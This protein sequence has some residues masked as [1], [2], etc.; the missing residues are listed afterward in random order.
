MIPAPAP[1]IGPVSD[2][3]GAA[4]PI[5]SEP[6]MPEPVAP[7]VEDPS[8]G[9]D[10]GR[11]NDPVL[12]SGQSP[13]LTVETLGPRR[14]VI[15]KK[16][17][18]KVAVR[19][20]G[21]VAAQDVILTVNVPA[22][23][24]IVG[25]EAQTAG[26]V[27]QAPGATDQI[28][29]KLPKLE[30]HSREEMLLG[31]IASEGVPLNLSVSLTHSPVATETSVEVSEPKLT[32]VLAGPEEVHYGKQEVF[33]LTL[34]NPGTA[35]AENVEL[36][37]AAANPGDSAPPATK[38]GL[39]PAGSRKVV[40]L[41]LTARQGGSLKIQATATANGNLKADVSETVLIR[42]P[43]LEMDLRGPTLRYSGTPGKYSLAL[44]NSGNSPAKEIQVAALLPAGAEFVSAEGGGTFNKEQGKIVWQLSTLEAE[45]TS[46]LVWVCKLNE[47]GEAK[48]QTACQAD[49]GLKDSANMVTEVEAIADLEMTVSDPRSPLPTGDSVVYDIVLRNRGTRKAENIELEAFLS[50]GL[51]AQ[52]PKTTGL[53][54]ISAGHVRFRR[55]DGIAPGQELTIQLHATGVVAGNQVVRVEMRCPSLDLSIAQEEATR[56]FGD[57]IPTDGSLELPSISEPAA[58]T[59]VGEGTTT[60][61]QRIRVPYGN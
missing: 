1:Q 56:F 8:T 44:H 24:E 14:V 31:V 38:L 47:I 43:E 11:M 55:I 3:P 51:E 50:A 5:A 2:S 18:F 36:L 32:M 19:N 23:V 34:S 10:S 41:E 20:T 33:R 25:T 21:S 61:P 40:E 35:D 26:F 30:R 54:E 60:T 6:T 59:A 7:P 46:E 22:S 52:Q 53:Y 37:L 29:W 28:Q 57:D 9:M 15:G 45:A 58:E 12:L 42:K 39:I 4:S 17:M 48:I 16:A 49:A 27:E 13:V